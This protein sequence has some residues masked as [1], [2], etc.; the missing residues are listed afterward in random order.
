MALAWAATVPR[1][2]A[3]AVAAMSAARSRGTTSRSGKKGKGAGEVEKTPAELKREKLAFE[4]AFG[5][6]EAKRL[7][8]EIRQ[9]RLEG[10][11][12][13]RVLND[14]QQQKAKID[15]FHELAKKE[16][17]DLKMSLR[18]ALRQ[19][20]DLEEKQAYEL[21]IYKGKVKQLLHEQQAGMT[22]VR[23]A[24]EE[25]LTLV[26]DESRAEQHSLS[27]DNRLVKVALKSAETEHA[28]FLVSLKT[29]QE[30]QIMILRAEYER[31]HV[32]LKE[33][34]DKKEKGVRLAAEEHRRDAVARLELLKNSHIADLMAKHKRRFD[35]IKKYYSDITHA[36]LE[37]IRN[38]KD[39]V[40][41]MKKKELAVQKEVADIRRVNK[42]LS[43]PLAKNRALVAQLQA[44]LQQYKQDKLLLAAVQTALAQ[45]EDR[46]KNTEWEFE[47]ATQKLAAL[48]EERDELD[49]K[50][51]EAVYGVQQKQG[52]KNLLL[53]KKL[54]A[55]S[56]DLEKTES[57][58]AEVLASTNLHP[59]IIGD[60]QHSLEDVLLAKNRTTQ[61]L[62]DGLAEMKRRY[63]RTVQ[64]YE[65]KMAE[66]QIPVEEL[67]FTA[68]RRL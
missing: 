36:N 38:L 21:K 35:K 52:F 28:D 65:A 62:E 34:Y 9:M 18:N 55:M 27:L 39:E 56:Q 31:R 45:L 37:L 24:H 41:D 12:E 25:N 2:A 13:L 57:A 48:R 67:G 47:V 5:S 59:E 44:D 68:T 40:G 60:I 11:N 33:H 6:D 29:E 49:K 53:E 26:Q 4:F 1:S 23:L 16:R 54:T 58:L 20:Q 66:Y 10:D 64:L 15:Q 42:R 14:S 32:E 50:L 19:K 46:V 43:R 63:A 8:A 17:E 7:R 30:K 51:S 3:A 22:D 61:R